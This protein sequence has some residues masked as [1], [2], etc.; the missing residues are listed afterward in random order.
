VQDLVKSFLGTYMHPLR[1]IALLTPR[2]SGSD[3][4]E[5]LKQAARHCVLEH[6][7]HSQLPP[8]PGSMADQNSGPGAATQVVGNSV[9]RISLTAFVVQNLF[10]RNSD[11]GSSCRN[12]PSSSA[13]Q[14]D[15]TGE[16]GTVLHEGELYG[17][18]AASMHLEEPRVAA[19]AQLSEA[20]LIKCVSEVCCSLTTP[21]NG[22]I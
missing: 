21:C 5:V 18:T 17:N 8:S 4:V 20:A 7:K 1:R 19:E 9:S 6:F 13:Q 2:Y 12:I 10:P 15:G 11:N 22:H 16:E 14:I 3:L